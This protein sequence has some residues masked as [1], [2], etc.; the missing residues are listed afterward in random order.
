[1]F[2]FLGSRRGLIVWQLLFLVLATSWLLAPSVNHLLSYRTALISQ[3]ETSGQAYSSVFRAADVLSGV[4]LLLMAALY[5]HRKHKI[6]SYLLLMIG[7]GFII[8]PVFTTS[9][10]VD[11]QVC[12]EYFSTSFLFHATETVIT[13]L[14]IF[15]IAVFDSWRRKKLV[16][17]FFV[18][19]Q[20]AYL[21]IFISQYATHTQFNTF[22][23]FLYQCGL[24]VWLAWF[25][26]DYLHEGVLKPS[27]TEGR[28]V[29]Y[30]VAGWAFL[31]GILAI[32]LSFT[33]IHLFGRIHGLYFASDTAWLAQHGVI[34]GIVML[35]LSRH[36]A[37]GE[38]RARQLFAGIVAIET[39]KYAVITPK[40][41]LVFFYG[42]TF[43]VIFVLRDDFDRGTVA[44]TWR[45]RLR[46]AYFMVASLLL[47]A[48]VSLLVLDR[49]DEASRIAARAFN[50]LLDYD[51]PRRA[52]E[53][54][55]LGSILLAHTATTFVVCGITAVL[56]ILFRPYPRAKNKDPGDN[57]VEVLLKRYSKSTEDYFKLW[58]NDKEYFWS[59]DKQGFIAYKVAGPVAF[60]LADP[61][62]NK[63]H[64]R[65]L[66][67]DFINWARARRLRVCFLPIPQESIPIYRD[68]PRVQIGA[69]ALIDTRVF[70]DSTVSDKWWRWQK[71][72][73]LKKGYSYTRSEP[74][75]TDSLLK[76]MGHVSDSWLEKSGRQ[77]RGFAL[78]YF[79]QPYMNA[80][81]VHYL[82]DESDKMVA[83]CNQ[84][85]S[86]RPSNT[87]TIDL[88]RH[89][90][91]AN[92]A[93]PYLLSETIADTRK[94]GQ[95]DYFDLGFVPFAAAKGPI[96]RVAKALSA[97]RFS[98]KGLEQF[99]NKFD[100]DW[101]PI[102]MTYDGDLGDL[103]LVALNLERAMELKS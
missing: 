58:P 13:A 96:L 70:L 103:A 17:V 93:M 34:I 54:N 22:F 86:F 23:Q 42:L 39:L 15:A 25:A 74:P 71:N 89:L 43:C 3:Y 52:V 50:H 88:L 28:I 57:R 35:Y 98:A 95:Y 87:T 33:H 36:L 16:S 6:A 82:T 66:V 63:S 46:D 20:L 56:W 67:D 49:D 84:L 97:G 32:L 38:M 27:V 64:G 72:R 78:G 91:E 19:F 99:K 75:H 47:A 92:N 45:V 48:F 62:A 18:V 85:P 11:G 60:A 40:A 77:E 44:A 8:D 102:H 61:I 51:L 53:R 21:G 7:L 90:P 79:D 5:L 2:E 4:L 24:V 30:V 14:A 69:S 55:H 83:F 101:Q 73:A 59:K 37:R 94:R 65:E 100:P 9:C 12:R 68:L 10:Q 1:M 80:C 76:E 31:N 81:I 41:P 26:R 29:K